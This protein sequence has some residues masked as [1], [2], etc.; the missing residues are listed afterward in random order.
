MLYKEGYF[1]NLW[2]D[3]QRLLAYPSMMKGPFTIGSSQ[4][5][6]TCPTELEAIV[7]H[8][9]M[10]TPLPSSLSTERLLPFLTQETVLFG[11]AFKRPVFALSVRKHRKYF[12]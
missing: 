10:L 6:V 4:M 5:T 2:M 11:G 1:E 9:F 8:N 3:T 7:V 12:A